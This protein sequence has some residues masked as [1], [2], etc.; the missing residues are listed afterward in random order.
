[1]INTPVLLEVS[2]LLAKSMPQRSRVSQRVI[3]LNDPEHNSAS[4]VRRLIDRF[5]DFYINHDIYR[6]HSCSLVERGWSAFQKVIVLRTQLA[7]SPNEMIFKIESQDLS[8]SNC[9]H[10][11]RF[12]LLHPRL[13]E[14]RTIFFRLSRS[15]NGG[16]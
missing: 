8:R 13:W 3:S 15:S 5:P 12:A 1:M 16:R 6:M 9:D 14:K 4:I 2:A 7:G 11:F 10:L